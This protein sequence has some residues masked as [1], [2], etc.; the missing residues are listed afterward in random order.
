[1]IICIVYIYI[2]L[3]ILYNIDYN[4]FRSLVFDCLSS[5]GIQ[6]YVE[7]DIQYTIPEDQVFSVFDE[8]GKYD[9]LLSYLQLVA[10][11]S[12]RDSC[13]EYSAESFYQAR[14]AI[15][16]TMEEGLT[17]TARQAK[18]HI[19]ITTVVLSNYEFPDDLDDAIKEKRSAENDI[20]IAENERDGYI[21]EAE[22]E[23][24][25]AK[26]NAEQLAIE[27]KAEVESVLAEADAQA[28]AITNVWENRQSVYVNIKKALN[29]TSTE[30]V[31]QYLSSVVLESA[32]DPVTT[33]S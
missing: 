30:F 27:A 23:L 28:T 9:N 3:Y 31:Y 6:M 26:V 2:Y 18:S 29:M 21:T 25:T 19:N 14:T 7:V 13:G 12:V 10:A 22:T 33:L 24:L 5:D 8:F 15:Q 16:T 11:D 4:L 17:I 20:E 32:T 1:M